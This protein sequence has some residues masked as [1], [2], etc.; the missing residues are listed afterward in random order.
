[1][2]R[3]RLLGAAAVAAIAFWLSPSAAHAKGIILITHGDTVSHLGTVAPQHR[4]ADLP[5]TAVGYKYSYF[6]I[7][8]IDLWTWGGTYCL[9][10]DKT[11]WELT[12]E[13]AA[14]LL[15]KSEAELSKPFLYTFPLGLLILA[16]LVVIGVLVKVFE[17]SP[18]QKLAAIRG[19]ERYQKALEIF[20][21]HASAPP[22]PA[23]A[24]ASE[25]IT[26][27]PAA[28]A[29][30]APPAPTEEE[31]LQARLAAG[32]EAAVEYLAS[33][34]VEREEAGRNLAALLSQP[35][36]AAASPGGATVNSQG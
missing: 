7:F 36:P 14:Q 19:E 22:E 15:G 10:Q 2:N 12:P 32:F 24:A 20:H 31:Q 33:Q 6:G 28:G 13:Q 29:T 8:W 26:A 16:P 34:G 4:G 23:P 3:P 1:M 27:A 21:T 25:A 17:K 11:Y 5:A 9:Y 35:Q 18:E 30:A